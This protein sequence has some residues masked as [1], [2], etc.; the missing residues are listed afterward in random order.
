MPDTLH[1]NEIQQRAIH[2][3]YDKHEQLLDQIIRHRVR[4]LEL[5]LHARGNGQ[6]G[7]WGRPSQPEW[8]IY[9]TP[10]EQGNNIL[11][12]GDALRLLKAFHEANS[13]HEVITLFLELK[14]RGISSPTLE[15]GTFEYYTPD[16][17]DRKIVNVLGKSNVFTPA[18]LLAANPGVATLFHAAGNTDAPRATPAR[19]WPTIEELRGK[20]VIIVHGHNSSTEASHPEIDDYANDAN[21]NQRVGFIMREDLWHISDEAIL[22]NKHIVFHGGVESNRVVQLRVRFPGLVLRGP[23]DK[24]KSGTDN[25]EEKFYA[26]QTEGCQLILTD[27]VD[28]HL[29]PFARTYNERLFPFGRAGFA[30]QEAWTHPSVK[31]RAE[32]GTLHLLQSRSGDLD[33]TADSFSFAYSPHSA[34]GQ[35]IWTAAVATTSNSSIHAWGKAV[36]MARASLSSSAPYFAV[37]RAADSHGLF[38]Q[39]RS[40]GCGDPPNSSPCGTA[41]DRLGNR[42]NI[43]DE[44][45]QFIRLKVEKRL[46]GSSLCRGYG[47]IDGFNWHQIGSDVI[48]L[49]DLPYRGIAAS[50]N[51]S[52]NPDGTPEWFFFQDLRRNGRSLAEYGFVAVSVSDGTSQVITNLTDYSAKA[53]LP[54]VSRNADGRLELFVLGG[55]G[56]IWHKWQTTPNGGWA[57]EWISLGGVDIRGTPAVSQNADG[58]LELF[59]L[60]GNE[61]IW[62]KWQTTPNGGWTPEW[63]SLGGVDI[64]G[65]PAVS[66]NADGRL[67]LFVLG[68]NGGIWHKWQTTPNGGWTPE[69]ISLGGVDIRGTPAVSRNAD[70]RL[71]LFVLGGNGGIWHK[72]QTTPNGG[73]TPEWISLGG[74]DIRGTPAVSRNADGRLELFVLGGNE[75]VWHKWQTTPNGGW[76]PE[77]ISLDG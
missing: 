5:D 66:Q 56:G 19:G 40:T 26:R 30:G 24:G 74:V 53:G 44:N 2:N 76:T 34:P 9:H 47:S 70:G 63:I 23:A 51:G 22:A 39:Y 14:A 57:P 7:H 64:Q 65:T 29:A 69:W 10:G 33:H 21:A 13:K 48:L 42:D 18:D 62:H 71:E 25:D 12:L 43:G 31:D 8:F 38:I 46:D 60:G 77:W 6:G 27:R 16:D 35:D 59:V 72:W 37:G 68:G 17:L 49:T 1:Y 58:R 28:T 55:N 50:S 61:G 20:F 41:Q 67:E 54:A 52:T 73:W 3:A 36:L 45:I 4:S 11:T 75:G 32:I 15:D